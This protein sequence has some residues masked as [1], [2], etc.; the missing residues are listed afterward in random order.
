MGGIG[1]EE[2]YG[3]CAFGLKFSVLS[4]GLVLAFFVFCPSSFLLHAYIYRR[5]EAICD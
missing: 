1:G 5:V 4:F 3:W 2:M